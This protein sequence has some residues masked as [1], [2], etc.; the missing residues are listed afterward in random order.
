MT[1]TGEIFQ[2][3]GGGNA[4]SGGVIALKGCHHAAIGQVVIRDPQVRGIWLEDSS[5]VAI[6]GS[7]IST[8]RP[9][10][11][12]IAAIEVSDSCRNIS[13]SGN[14]VSQ[15]QNSAIKCNLKSGRDFNTTIL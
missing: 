1:I 5:A 9:D 6:S 15:G 11:K 3:A 12:M 10:S 14:I 2:N 13:M 7:V 8:T 4:S